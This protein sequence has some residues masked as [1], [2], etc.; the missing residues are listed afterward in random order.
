M[1]NQ[2]TKTESNE[3]G[4]RR[5]KLNSS[6]AGTAGSTPEK[7]TCLLA[8]LHLRDALR[9]TK[10]VETQTGRICTHLD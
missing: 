9:P 1:P 4:E 7:G 5:G 10:A 3:V 6:L 8:I 2:Q